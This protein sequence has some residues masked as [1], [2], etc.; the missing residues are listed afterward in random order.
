MTAAELDGV[1]NAHAFLRVERPPTLWTPEAEL[2]PFI[3]MLGELIVVGLGR[4]GN[5]LGELTLN[6]ANVTVEPAAGGSIPKGDFVAV[7]IRGQGDWAPET[8]WTAPADVDEIL[9]SVKRAAQ[10][11]GAAQLYS[12]VLG[13]DEG[14]VTVLL[15]RQATST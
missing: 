6:V 7:T 3:R 9:E 10:V 11:A 12:R 4:N 1:L 15:P 14:S 2:E 5:V 13:P 8:T